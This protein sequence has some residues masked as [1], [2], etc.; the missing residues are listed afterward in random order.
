[1]GR[2][3]HRD[4]SVHRVDI[5]RGKVKV[6]V[7][8]DIGVKTA[9]GVAL[10]AQDGIAKAKAKWMVMAKTTHVSRVGSCKGHTTKDLVLGIV[11]VVVGGSMYGEREGR[12][13]HEGDK[14]KTGGHDE[15][16]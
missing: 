6:L 4:T 16:L 7:I 5:G 15:A 8:P 3:K 14:G 10:L 9:D 12:D 11:R 13:D 2:L 1:M